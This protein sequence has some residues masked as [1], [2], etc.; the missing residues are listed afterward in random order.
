MPVRFWE[1]CTL[2]IRNRYLT[3]PQV[4]LGDLIGPSDV[5][6]MAQTSVDDCLNF[7][8]DGVCHAPG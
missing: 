7:V 1:Q 6:D 3:I 5:E 4:C 2:I 8:G